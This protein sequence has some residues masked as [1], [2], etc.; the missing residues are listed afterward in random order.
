LSYR[1]IAATKKENADEPPRRKDAKVRFFLGVLASWRF[2]LVFGM[3]L[4]QKQHDE[5]E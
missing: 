4:S 3:M 2:N 1:G 5:G